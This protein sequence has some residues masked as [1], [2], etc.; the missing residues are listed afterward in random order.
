MALHGDAVAGVDLTVDAR[1]RTKMWAGRRMPAPPADDASSCRG[2]PPRT[3]SRPPLQNGWHAPDD[4]GPDALHSPPPEHL[5]P[6]E[7][8]RLRDG[9]VRRAHDA[10][11]HVDEV[12][13]ALT[14]RSFPRCNFCTHRGRPRAR[15]HCWPRHDLSPVI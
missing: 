1:N 9:G 11:R 5:S 7:A 13:L 4:L 2:A 15:S 12:Y 10:Q 6:P 3:L 14:W 8:W